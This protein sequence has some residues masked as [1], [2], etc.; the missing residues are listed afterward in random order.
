MSVPD[1]LLFP[2]S[3]HD[4]HLSS[5]VVMAPMSRRRSTPQHLP[6]DITALY[7]SQR[8]GAGLVI[9]ENAI[10]APDGH[11]YLHIPAIYT[12]EQT[13]AWKKVAAAVH[14]KQGKIFMQLVHTGRMGHALNNPGQLPIVG[15]SAIAASGTIRIPGNQYVPLPVPEALTT[16]GAR[17]IIQQHIQAASNAIA[18]GFDGVEIHSAHGYLPDQFLNPHLN[19][20]TDR[21]GGSIANRTRLLLEITEGIVSAIGKHRTGVRLS[22]FAR[23]NDYFAYPEEAATHKYI[24]DALQ[25]LDILYIHLSDQP[26][27]GQHS[28]TTDWLKEIR[29][30]FNNWLIVAGG[31]T[32]ASAEAVLKAGLADLVAFG[33]PFIANPDLVERFRHNHPLAVPDESTF[34]E[35]GEKGYIDYPVFNR[36]ATRQLC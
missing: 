14:E 11:G 1:L 35:G 29:S 26:V 31:Y 36:T 34:Y 23:I 12:R 15:P 33:K 21:Y 10:V 8:A 9:T 6:A 18:A 2:L 24:A 30:R 19:N 5:R 4:L 7:Y 20:R 27:N 16:P 28:L 17:E 3:A 13:A 32:A 25:Q 22:P